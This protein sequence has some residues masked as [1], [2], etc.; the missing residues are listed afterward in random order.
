MRPYWFNT[1]VFCLVVFAAGLAELM[2]RRETGPSIYLANKAIASTALI[3][4]TL[5]FV[6]SAVHYFWKAPNRVLL[7]RRTLGLTG[8]GFAAL[9]IA[10]TL[11]TPDPAG[12]TQYKFPFPSYYTD[13]LPAML[14]AV[15]G[16]VLFTYLFVIS[17]RAERF[18]GTPEKAKVWRRR[19]RYGYIGVLLIFLHSFLLKAEGWFTWVTTF[20]PTLP[21]LSLIVSALVLGMIVLKVWHLRRVGRVFRT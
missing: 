2:I 21:P 1:V 20:V 16:F 7:Y 3:A 17:I 13:H 4:I 5:S 11:F 19:L 8:Y 15:A 10:T 14:L 18:T 6:V 9:H 12:S